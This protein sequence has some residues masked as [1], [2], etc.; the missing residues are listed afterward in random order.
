MVKVIAKTASSKCICIV[1]YGLRMKRNTL[2]HQGKEKLDTFQDSVH[3]TK[4]SVLS[5]G[6]NYSVTAV[7]LWCDREQ[8]IMYI[9]YYV[10]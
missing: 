4:D 3:Y 8:V 9:I 7:E 2:S 6:S 5:Q 10:I 1:L